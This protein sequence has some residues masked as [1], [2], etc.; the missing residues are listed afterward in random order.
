M[1]RQVPL[2]K[3]EMAACILFFQLGLS[4]KHSSCRSFETD[5]AP[6]DLKL[7]ILLQDDMLPKS[8]PTAL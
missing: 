6:E 5:C 2:N 7:E 4:F 8:K 1:T 3:L